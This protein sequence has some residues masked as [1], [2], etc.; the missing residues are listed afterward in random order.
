MNRTPRL[1]I[2][3]IRKPAPCEVKAESKPTNRKPKIPF[4]LKAMRA[5]VRSM[6]Q[7]P[8]AM[9]VGVTGF[10]GRGL[11]ALLRG[12]GLACTGVS[13]SGS[14]RIDGVDRWQTPDSMDPSGHQVVINLAGEPINRRWNAHNKR[15]FH[16]SRIGATRRI[17][18]TIRQVPPTERPKALV[19]ASAI[20]IYGDGG[21]QWLDESSPPGA[22][23][24]AD[25]CDEWEKTAQE[26]AA[27]GLR[28][29]MPRTGIVLG[30]DG[31]AFRQLRM[32]FKSGIGGRLGSGR[33]WMPWIHIDD[34]R[35]AIVHAACSETMSGPFNGCAPNPVRNIDFTRKFAAALHRPV[36]FP[37]PGWAL[38]L[39]L[40]GFGGALLAGQRARPGALLADGFRFQY[41]TL[42]SALAELLSR[43]ARTG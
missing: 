16:Q 39:A 27:L 25:L 29:A 42:E 22:G 30:R 43:S 36:I 14:G 34:M 13:R 12:R 11:P 41:P 3:G 32:V 35:A 23:Y 26:A 1:N 6:D 2:A 7:Q 37:V 18:E 8:R 31:A 9:I 20:G 10:I 28:V 5:M 38:K 33:Q 21:D 17:I 19:N 15:L 40:G 24:L 4:Y